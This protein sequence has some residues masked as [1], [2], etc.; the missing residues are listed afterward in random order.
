MKSI[1]LIN[2]VAVVTGGAGQLGR[3]MVRGLAECG[4]NVVICYY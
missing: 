2:K 1:D 3:A 4:A